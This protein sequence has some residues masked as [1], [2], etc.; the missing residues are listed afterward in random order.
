ME[1]IK[2]KSTTRYFAMKKV[3]VKSIEVFMRKKSPN[4]LSL[5]S[6]FGDNGVLE[7]F[8]KRQTIIDYLGYDF[9]AKKAKFKK[10]SKVNGKLFSKTQI[11]LLYAKILN[12]MY[13]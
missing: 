5:V 13:F 6:E 2:L 1:T 8:V 12:E 3:I 4:E 11:V 7:V 10:D 9:R